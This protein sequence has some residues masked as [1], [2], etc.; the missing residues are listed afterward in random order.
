MKKRCKS[1]VFYHLPDEGERVARRMATQFDW[2]PRSAASIR[3]ARCEAC[4]SRVEVTGRMVACPN[5]TTARQA[6]L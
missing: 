3:H 4:D 6:D 1:C 5:Y 2:P